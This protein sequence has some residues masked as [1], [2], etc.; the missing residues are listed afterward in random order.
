MDKIFYNGRVLTIEDKEPVTE[1]LI[2]KDSLI[3]GVGSNEKMLSEKNSKTEIIDLQ[4]RTLVPGFNDSH[5]HVVGY[6][7]NRSRV[8]LSLCTSLDQLV[9]AIRKFIDDNSVSEDEWVFGWG[10]NHALFKEKRM[11]DRYD[12]DRAS[13]KHNIAILRTCCHLLSANSRALRAAGIEEKPQQI[14]GGSIEVDDNGIPTGV[15][16]ERAMLPVQSFIPSLDGPLLKKMIT[17][18]ARDFLASGLTSVQ[19]DDLLS[20]GTDKLSLLFKVYSELAEEGNL[21]LRVN[22]QVQLP[23]VSLLEDYLNSGFNRVNKSQ[24]LKA[25]PVKLIVDGSLGG[26][27]A[28]MSEPYPD[29]P[30]NY[31]IAVIG[32][33]KLNELVKLAHNNKLQV[34]AHAIGDAAVSMVLDAYEEAFRANS[35]PDPRFRIIHAS[36]VSDRDLQRFKEN[37]VIA[38]IQPSFIASDYSQLNSRFAPDFNRRTYRWKDFINNDI[39][40]AGSSDSPIESFSPLKGIY[41][42]VTRMDESGEPKGGWFSDQSLSLNEALTAYTIGSAYSEFEEG[43]KGSLRKGKMADL[44]VLSDDIYQV[45]PFQLKDV[46]VDM[47]IVG[48]RLVYNRHD[49]HV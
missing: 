46:R 16:S 39:V 28:L 49:L 47:T 14:D 38:N 42:A 12:L 26:K 35:Y 40:L 32:K 11:P 44:L 4:G 18:A 24:Y 6:A 29:D 31:G 30:G 2:I 43:K 20:L 7:M 41:A 22:L 48:G 45:D 33:D 27:T 15:L 1:A 37:N 19:T 23:E 5:L 36:V 9:E 8:D 13:Q 25:G 34:A 3:A 17:D 21:P 10:W